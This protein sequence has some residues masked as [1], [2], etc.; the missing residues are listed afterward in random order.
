MSQAEYCKYYQPQRSGE[1]PMLR[2][3]PKGGAG[4]DDVRRLIFRFLTQAPLRGVSL[5]AGITLAGTLAVMSL[6][7]AA[8]TALVPALSAAAGP[9]GSTVSPTVTVIAPA[10]SGATKQRGGNILLDG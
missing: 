6:P 1:I 3:A 7:N 4:L 5:F 8:K 2:G 9:A 10:L